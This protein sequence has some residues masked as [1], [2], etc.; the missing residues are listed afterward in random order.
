MSE[1]RP[2]GR[3]F[4]R[5]RW[6]LRKVLLYAAAETA[7]AAGAVAALVWLLARS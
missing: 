1:E 5:T 6:P 2:G 7:V 4:S 3:R